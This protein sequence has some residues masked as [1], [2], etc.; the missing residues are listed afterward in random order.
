LPDE[1]F[2]GPP[3]FVGVGTYLAG[4]EWWMRMLTQHPQVTGPRGGRLGLYFFERFCTREMTDENVA[5]YHDRFQRG[6]GVVAGEFSNRYSYDVWTLPLVKRAAPQAKI[7]MILRDPVEHYRRSLAYR[8]GKRLSWHKRHRRGA[9]IY[10][11]ED[12]HRSRFGA[13]LRALTHFFPRER[14]LVLQLE[15]LLR[16]PVA[17]YARTLRFLGVRDDFVPRALRRPPRTDDSPIEQCRLLRPFGLPPEIHVRPLRRLLG[18][19]VPVQLELWED[20]R[21]SLLAELTEEVETLR[22]FDPGFDLSLW[23]SFAHVA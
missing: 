5:A 16:D 19:P 6:P 10:M 12:V 9:P 20:I 11:A 4:T 22:R 7:L 13:Q 1:R 23:P 21:A 2:T 3:D 17:E 18:R 14:I 15:R 8:H